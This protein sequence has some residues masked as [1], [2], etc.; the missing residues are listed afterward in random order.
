MFAQGAMFVRH[1]RKAAFSLLL[2]TANSSDLSDLTSAD[3]GFRYEPA[4]SCLE[5]AP[6]L[7]NVGHVT[8]IIEE[9]TW[10][11]Q[12]IM[13]SAIAILASELLGY[14]VVFNPVGTLV[15]RFDIN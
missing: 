8:I 15:E 11:S 13:A 12:K 1:V 10:R 2:L 3:K 14:T 7:E 6:I 4:S 5:R 9:S